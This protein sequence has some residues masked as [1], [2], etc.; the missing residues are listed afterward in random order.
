VAWYT[1]RN[2]SFILSGCLYKTI[3]VSILTVEQAFFE[4]GGSYNFTDDSYNFTR[5]RNFFTDDSCN[6]TRARNFFTDESYNFTKAINFFTD[7]S[8]NFT[9]GYYIKKV[10]YYTKLLRVCKFQAANCFVLGACCSEYRFYIHLN[11]YRN[12]DNA[13]KWSVEILIS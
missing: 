10:G 6:F 8:Y 13:S 4:C 7:E 9:D 2:L 12:V 11:V 1:L 3:E 5:A